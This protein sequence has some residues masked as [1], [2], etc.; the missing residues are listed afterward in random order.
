M[1]FFLSHTNSQGVSTVSSDH[2]S[3]AAAL[4]YSVDICSVAQDNLQPSN[5]S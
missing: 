4:V 2:Q 3:R 5:T 1:T